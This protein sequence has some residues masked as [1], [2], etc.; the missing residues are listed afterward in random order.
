MLF[1]VGLLLVLWTV[2]SHALVPRALLA[3]WKSRQVRLAAG[4]GDED[5]GFGIEQG[6]GEQKG[7]A[8]LSLLYEGM[9]DQLVGDGYDELQPHRFDSRQACKD[10]LQ[11][12][13]RLIRT[14]VQS[15]DAEEMDMTVQAMYEEKKL[16]PQSYQEALEYVDRIHSRLKDLSHPALSA[17][18][19]ILKKEGIGR[20]GQIIRG[21]PLMTIREIVESKRK[22]E[23][24]LSLT[25]VLLIGYRTSL[26]QGPDAV[27]DVLYFSK[28]LLER[29][30]IH[31]RHF[32][33][34]LLCRG[35]IAPPLSAFS[36]GDED[37]S[38]IFAATPSSV[39][40]EQQ[41]KLDPEWRLRALG[42]PNFSRALA[43]GMRREGIEQPST[44]ARLLFPFLS[45]PIRLWEMRA[46]SRAHRAKSKSSEDNDDLFDV[47][48]TAKT[49]QHDPAG[50]LLLDDFGAKNENQLVGDDNLC[51]MMSVCMWLDHQTELANGLTGAGE[52][53]LQSLRLWVTD[54]GAAHLIAEHDAVTSAAS[55]GSSSAGGAGGA[56]STGAGASVG[57]GA[58]A[59]ARGAGAGGS[60]GS[61]A[62]SWPT[63]TPAPTP[64][65]TTAVLPEEIRRNT[66]AMELISAHQA[67]GLGRRSDR[68]SLIASLT[69]LGAQLGGVARLFAD[70]PAGAAAAA[71]AAVDGPSSALGETLRQ[72][73]E[74]ALATAKKTIA[75]VSAF[76]ALPSASR[77]RRRILVDLA[78][79]SGN[80]AVSSGDAENE[81]EDEGDLWG[82][83]ML[84]GRPS[85][86]STRPSLRPASSPG[87]SSSSSSS[88]SLPPLSLSRLSS[89]ELDTLLLR[90]VG[91]MLRLEP[92]ALVDN[93]AARSE[94]QYVFATWR[95]PTLLLD[96]LRMHSSSL[97]V[98]QLFR[99]FLK[100][101]LGVSSETVDGIRHLDPGNRAMLSRF[102]PQLVAEWTEGRTSRG[103]ALPGYNDAQTLFMLG[104]DSG[105][106]M[107]IRPRQKGTNR[108]LLSFLLHGN[109]RILGR[110]DS[111]GRLLER[112]VVLLAIDQATQRAV[113]FV[114]TPFGPNAASGLGATEVYDQAGELGRLLSLPV[115]YAAAPDPRSYAMGPMEIHSLDR[116][117]AAGAGGVDLD[118]D[119]YDCWPS[120]EETLT[121][122]DVDDSS[123]LD[124]ADEKDAS[125][126]Q[127]QD[128]DQDRAQES[129]PSLSQVDRD[130]G[131]LS[132]LHLAL[133]NISD[134][135]ALAPYVWVDGITD[136]ATNRFS[137][138]R[139][140][141][142]SKRA[143]HREAVVVGVRTVGSIE[144][145]EHK[146]DWGLCGEPE[147]S[148]GRSFESD[149]PESRQDEAFQ[150][151]LAVLARAAGPMRRRGSSAGAAS[152]STRRRPPLTTAPGAP[153][154]DK[155]ASTTSTAEP[156]RGV[157]DNSLVAKLIQRNQFLADR[158]K[159]LYKVRSRPAAGDGEGLDQGQGDDKKKAGRDLIMVNPS[160]GEVVQDKP[161][162]DRFA[163]EKDPAVMPIFDDDGD[164]LFA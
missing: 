91:D 69:Q 60:V 45:F 133:V 48:S 117:A 141:L 134:Y 23:R 68:Q 131:T 129:R 121:L 3:P 79:H 149:S 157:N 83:A 105:T 70:F 14:D 57:A 80:G 66:L 109:V 144:R 43:D 56:G 110:K 18:K 32:S 127:D 33:L 137:V 72:E 142:L 92:D 67:L 28:V 35:I 39:T 74:E 36:R 87:S 64:A 84:G 49:Q 16:F 44:V 153:S 51:R 6:E 89:Y 13:L 139:T 81:N 62:A 11:L 135:T 158:T 102:P 115:V 77:L 2:G 122:G 143:V 8:R 154:Q 22:I 52:E 54:V 118:L 12:M 27:A 93:A 103:E 138:G 63:S 47:R 164:D 88:S 21:S 76:R 125:H 100:A 119:F 53:L 61:G 150:L 19:F 55:V 101:L 40:A 42:R 124:S 162:V 132:S 38:S 152:G 107:M 136:P 58:G 34:L 86:K 104:E 151:D 114:E 145:M 140:P 155:T 9:Y 159:R 126:H 147:V 46:Q 4:E 108:G 1:L 31:E 59:P 26:Q 148:A 90:L 113:L 15:Q 75:V 85:A 71:A 99:R 7:V 111:S 112:A 163:G 17:A 82:Q 50:L 123:G 73:A 65:P 130:N 29:V 156:S 97:P 120:E 24:S 10:H 25:L 20:V 161:V 146:R 78:P 30:P 128:Q 5:L 41:A 96:Y 160:S 94:L 116:A 106:C 37:A 95:R 98:Q